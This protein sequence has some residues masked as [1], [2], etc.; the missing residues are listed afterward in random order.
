M[1]KKYR[2]TLYK[3]TQEAVLIAAELSSDAKAWGEFCAAKLCKEKPGRDKRE[4]AV[5]YVFEAVF[6]R[7]AKTI[8]LYVRAVKALRKQG[9]ADEEIADALKKQGGFKKVTAKGVAD[10]KK[11]KIQKP[12]KEGR[13]GITRIAGGSQTILVKYPNEAKALKLEK[14]LGSNKKKLASGKIVL[15][16]DPDIDLSAIKPGV[17]FNIHT[18]IAESSYHGAD[19]VG[20]LR[21]G[22]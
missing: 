3:L 13:D 16:V 11:K 8:S 19:L 22:D 9:T 14:M 4:Q 12:S 21:L 17:P 2:E 18:V 10:R 7:D 1:R 5:R 15:I 6:K 20:E